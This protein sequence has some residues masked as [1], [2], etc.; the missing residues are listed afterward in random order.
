MQGEQAKSVSQ[1]QEQAILGYLDT[2][3]YPSRDRVMFLLSM[4]PASGKRNGIADV[5]MVTDAQGPI[6]EAMHVGSVTNRCADTYP[7]RQ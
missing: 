5:A 4:R 7:S 2:T 6:A 3:H 1:T